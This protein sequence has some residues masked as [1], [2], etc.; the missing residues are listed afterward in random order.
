MINFIS[1]DDVLS[2]VLDALELGW[3][4]GHA[5]LDDALAAVLAGGPQPLLALARRLPRTCKHALAGRLALAA[6]G[7][8]RGGGD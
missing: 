3:D 7:G 6:L 5:Q 4:P 2:H 1:N 8:R